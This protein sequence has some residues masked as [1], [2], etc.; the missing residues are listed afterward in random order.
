MVQGFLEVIVGLILVDIL[1]EQF[2]A[3]DQ[4]IRKPRFSCQFRKGKNF[5]VFMDPILNI[6]FFAFFFEVCYVFQDGIFFRFDHGHN[7]G[8]TNAHATVADDF[9]IVDR[10]QENTGNERG[11]LLMEKAGH[12][13][14]AL[15]EMMAVE[16]D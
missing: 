8:R 12:V 10:T 9:A 13:E 2:A 11:F 5:R 15:T 7:Y 3:Q 4:K 14:R 6:E 1:V 16:S